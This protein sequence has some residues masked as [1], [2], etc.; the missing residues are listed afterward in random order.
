MLMP[1]VVMNNQLK[2]SICSGKKRNY[3]SAK[4]LFTKPLGVV[5]FCAQFML[6]AGQLSSLQTIVGIEFH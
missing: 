1:I 4:L 3:M 5:L 2:Q 6:A